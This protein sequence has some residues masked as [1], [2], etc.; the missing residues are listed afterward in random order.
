MLLIF[1]PVETVSANVLLPP[2]LC[3]RVISGSWIG[4]AIS[5]LMI[6]KERRPLRAALPTPACPLSLGVREAL[7][8]QA[9]EMRSTDVKGPVPGGG[10]F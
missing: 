8:E 9:L 7:E 4:M 10:A 2:S 1:V 6:P 3:P 5:F